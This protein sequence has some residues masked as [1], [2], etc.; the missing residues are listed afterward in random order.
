MLTS[1]LHALSRKVAPLRSSRA[2]EVLLLVSY[3]GGW[4]GGRLGCFWGF[5]LAFVNTSRQ[6]QHPPSFS[7]LPL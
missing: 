4:D 2:G 1:A 6:L 7:S 3:L 5:H